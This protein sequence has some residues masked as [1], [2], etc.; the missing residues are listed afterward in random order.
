VHAMGRDDIY[1]VRMY[2]GSGNRPQTSLL[3]IHNPDPWRAPMAVTTVVNTPDD[4]CRKHP[5]HVE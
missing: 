2:E 4:G 3:D 5:K 1:L